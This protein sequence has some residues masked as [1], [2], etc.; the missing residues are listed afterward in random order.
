MPDPTPAVDP[1]AKYKRQPD[2]SSP[3]RGGDPYAKYK[4]TAPPDK[5]KDDKGFFTT[6][7][8]DV[9][10]IPGAAV[11]AVTSPKK[12]LDALGGAQ[13]EQFEEG[14]QEFKKG[15][16]AESA[17]H[18][19]AGAVPVLG[20]AAAAAAKDLDE[21]RYG[22]GA[23][24]L[25][26]LFGPDIAKAL[27][28][29]WLPK[30]SRSVEN[31]N[32]PTEEKAL[33]SVE[34]EVRMTPGQR[35]GQAALQ[36][37]EKNLKNAPGTASQ[38][39]QFY[40]GQESDLATAG[41]RRVSAQGGQ[42]TN[43]FGAGS[44]VQETLGARISR[45]KEYADKLYDSTRKT[46]ARNA[47]DV[48]TGTT[49][50]AAFDPTAPLPQSRMVRLESPVALGPVRKQLQSVYEELARNLPEAKRANSPAFRALDEFMKS[51]S[52]HMNAMD[53]DKFLGAV[54]SITRDGNSSILSSQSQR[55]AKLVVSAGEKQFQDAI[56][57]AGPNVVDKLQRARKAVAEYHNT[58]DF[59]ED[60][61]G[62]PGA[63]YSNLTT[64]GDRVQNTLK[65][66][67]QK[68]PKAL[69]TVGRTYLEQMM[70][71]ATREGGFGRSAGVKADWEKL[72]P[73]T[74][75]LIFG[76]ATTKAMDEF[77]LAAKKLTPA[78]G[79]ATAD[80][81]SALTQYGDI[82]AAIA[83]FVGGTALGH[84]AAGAAG[85]A[86]TLGK[87]RLQPAILAK[88]SFKPLGAQLLK[89]SITLPINSPKWN[90]AMRNLTA[91][92]AVE[93]EQEDK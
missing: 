36:T 39:E 4:R 25:L 37:S 49:A 9:A 27:P 7:A 59:L 10:S 3:G 77:L 57:G 2:Q 16:Y 51:G 6:L 69:Q 50:G 72:G 91:M 63:L 1:Y 83:E 43:P 67:G 75:N 48:E 19:V 89:Q 45:L 79:S 40:S 28:E 13:H 30:I 21:G 54:K 73:E 34:N 53:F 82:G 64:G 68:A 33:K 23:A 24:H 66:I 86:A 84:P 90:N 65:E 26:E 15:N 74:K 17:F 32:N 87:T 41:R 93:N 56:A 80:R 22:E 52:D 38:A 44:A 61:N 12:T 31:V 47:K 55:L 18:T 20:P 8:T 42:V 60:L 71:K 81:L 29:K 5:K 62:E 14:R 76:P 11:S 70:D 78:Q 35:A 46:T 88:L 58:A 92:A 85:A